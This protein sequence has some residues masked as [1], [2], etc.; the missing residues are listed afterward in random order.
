[1]G[2]S[3][4]GPETLVFFRAASSDIRALAGHPQTRILADNTFR[5]YRGRAVRNLKRQQKW[6]VTYSLLSLVAPTPR[7]DASERDP[8]QKDGRALIIKVLRPLKTV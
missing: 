3:V 6:R 4:P 7:R 5:L 2:L 8:F 1:V